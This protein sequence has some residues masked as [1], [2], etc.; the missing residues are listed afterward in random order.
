MHFLEGQVKSL[1]GQ[2]RVDHQDQ[3]DQDLHVPH[4][5]LCHMHR[6]MR[7]ANYSQPARGHSLSNDRQVTSASKREN[8]GVHTTH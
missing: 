2:A 3:P 5:R 1:R 6:G 8:S 7:P 4:E